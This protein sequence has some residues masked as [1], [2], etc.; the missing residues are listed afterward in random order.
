MAEHATVDVC[1]HRV[2]GSIPAAETTSGG[3]AGDRS[4]AVDRS[5][6]EDRYS[7]AI[8]ESYGDAH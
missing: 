7:M 3:V 6:V 4:G 1:D 2:A 8:Q 5:G